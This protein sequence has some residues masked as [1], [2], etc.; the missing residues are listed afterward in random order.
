MF[1]IKHTTPM[2]NEALIETDEVSYCP[3]PEPQ[4]HPDTR[5]GHTTGVLW[6]KSPVTGHL[7]PISEGMTY[8]MN[9]NGS[10]IAKYDLGGWAPPSRLEAA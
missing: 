9:D 4:P 1:T 3:H 10:T 2:G 6:Y 5:L 8:V 7:V